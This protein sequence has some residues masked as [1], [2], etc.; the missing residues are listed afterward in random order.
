MVKA[1]Q[2]IRCKPQFFFVFGETQ[3]GGNTH[4]D[5][6]SMYCR[7]RGDS[8]IVFLT[9]HHDR[10]A[11]ILWFSL[12]GNI[13]SSHDL[14]PGGNCRKKAVVVNHFFIKST[15]DPV[16]DTHFTFQCFDMDITGSLADRLFQQRPYQLNDRCVT[17]ICS[18]LFSSINPKLLPFFCKTS[19][20]I[21]RFRRTIPAVDGCT[22][23]SGSCD[24][25]LHLEI[26]HNGNIINRHHIHRIRHSQMQD[27]C[28]IRIQFKG[29]TG[30]LFQKID[31]DQAS[32]FLRDRYPRQLD[33]LKAK[34]HLQCPY[35]HL[36]RDK[37]IID[38][39]LSDLFAAALLQLQSLFQFF[40]SQNILFDQKI[41]QSHPFSSNRHFSFISACRTN[42]TSTLFLLNSYTF[43]TISAIICFLQKITHV[44]NFIKKHQNIQ[45]KKLFC[46]PVLNCRTVFISSSGYPHPAFG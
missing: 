43:N 18:C 45:A 13:H 38:Q 6:F 8:D 32:H 46:N 11:S 15:I 37:T 2:L 21:Q 17:D 31:T 5:L 7:Y 26:G 40:L 14:D 9:I 35:D 27:I 30:I 23:V 33:N 12:F 1:F 10:H 22:D 25:R 42:L 28:I 19:G 34:L 41:S 16:T 39:N 20:C 3:L 29:N 4:N 44:A 36:F 24:I